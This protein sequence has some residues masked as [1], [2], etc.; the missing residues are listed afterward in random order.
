MNAARR[1]IEFCTFAT[2]SAREYLAGKTWR[3]SSVDRVSPGMAT[4]SGHF[5]LGFTRTT[6]AWFSQAMRAKARPP[7]QQAAALSGWCSRREA[8]PT[9]RLSVHGSPLKWTASA[10]PARRAAADEPHPLPIG[11]SLVMRSASGVISS[12]SDCRTSR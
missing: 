1:S 3:A 2:A 12:H 9:I 10:M 5:P 8:S 11:I 4:I 6:C 7:T